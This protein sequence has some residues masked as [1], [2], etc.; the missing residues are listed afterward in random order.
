MCYLY[1]EKKHE[2]KNIW[3]KKQIIFKMTNMSISLMKLLKGDKYL[4]KLSNQVVVL[5]MFRNSSEDYKPGSTCGFNDLS[6]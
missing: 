2:E 4:S 3:R 5:F 1:E 6:F